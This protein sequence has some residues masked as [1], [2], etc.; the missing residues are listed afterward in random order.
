ML[1]SLLAEKPNTPT[2]IPP[3]PP[4]VISATPQDNIP[5]VNKVPAGE[6][7]E[8]L[9]FFLFNFCERIW[10]HLL[11]VISLENQQIYFNFC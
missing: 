1:A 6:L 9:L 11:L 5:R 4:S 2:H 7:E 10:S 3:I 8:Q